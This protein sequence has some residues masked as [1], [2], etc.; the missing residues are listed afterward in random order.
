MQGE[1]GGGER[2]DLA[3]LGT[4]TVEGA[5]ETAG[6]EAGLW[7]GSG[8]GGEAVRVDRGELVAAAGSLAGST[9][10]CSAAS[11]SPVACSSASGDQN[12]GSAGRPG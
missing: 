11:A 2:Q 7:R 1:A 10:P 6:D 9:H 4:E 5:E 3:K 8:D 12:G